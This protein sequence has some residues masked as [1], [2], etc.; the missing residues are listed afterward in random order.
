MELGVGK[1]FIQLILPS[2]LKLFTNI[3]IVFIIHIVF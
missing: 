3:K 1:Q 2:S